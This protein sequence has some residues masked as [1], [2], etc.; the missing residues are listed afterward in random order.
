MAVTQTNADSAGLSP[1]SY[2]DSNGYWYLQLGS[3]RLYVGTGSP[4]TIIT[5]PE[6]SLYVRNDVAALHLNTTGAAVWKVAT[7]S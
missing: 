1:I 3:I 6:G 4:D 5:A 2:K 7:F